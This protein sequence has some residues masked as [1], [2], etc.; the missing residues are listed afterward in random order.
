MAIDSLPDLHIDVLS[1]YDKIWYGQH[2]H[3]RRLDA[4]RPHLGI[5]IL[6]HRL[7]HV[8][9]VHVPYGRR[10]SYIHLLVL[11]VYF[12]LTRR[13]VDPCGYLD[14]AETDLLLLVEQRALRTM[15]PNHQVQ[16]RHVELSQGQVVGWLETKPEEVPRRSLD[17]R[18]HPMEGLEEDALLLGASQLVSPFEVPSEKWIH[19]RELLV[20]SRGLVNDC[21]HLQEHSA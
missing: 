1:L 7:D 2:V 19:Y 9:V 14:G 4:L 6:H 5:A 8:N 18:L 3:R 11:L 12:K 20:V 17:K 16:T 21:V 10:G 15:R 13:Y